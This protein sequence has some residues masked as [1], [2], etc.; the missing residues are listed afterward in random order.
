LVSEVIDKIRSKGHWDVVIRPGTFDEQRVDYEALEDVLEPIAVRLRGWPVP[1]VD[2]R[3]QFLRGEDWVGQ[4]IDAERVSHYEAWRFFTSGQFNHLRAVSADWRSE[5][6]YVS[7]ETIV[8]QGFT[9][10]IEVWEILFYLTEVF[11]LATRL[12]LSPAGDES[13]TVS[14]R[15]D[16]LGRRAL[17]VGQPNRM[18]FDSPYG[19][20]PQTLAR[21]AT[22]SREELAADARGAAVEMARGLFLRFGW[23][24]SRDQLAEWQR[25]LLGR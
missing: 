3:E 2:R 4:D 18:P 25:E 14:V 20:P 24:P 15:L 5:A 1:Y 9:S 23:K 11:E 21:E 10:A 19:P 8:P 22:L 17:V 7:G 13:M 16:G 6:I 12:S